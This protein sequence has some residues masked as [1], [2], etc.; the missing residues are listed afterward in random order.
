MKT[1]V[2]IF[3]QHLEALAADIQLIDPP[4]QHSAQGHLD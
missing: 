3:V 1:T 2:A 4:P